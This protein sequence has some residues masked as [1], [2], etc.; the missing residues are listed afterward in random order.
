MCMSG[1]AEKK[2]RRDETCII[3]SERWARKEGRNPPTR[4]SGLSWISMMHD[5]HDAYAEYKALIGR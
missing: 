3:H 1:G 4:L 2:G 5:A